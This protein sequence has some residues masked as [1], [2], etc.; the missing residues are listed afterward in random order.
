MLTVLNNAI[1]F[2]INTLT[3]LYVFILIARFILVY[4]RNDSRSPTTRLIAK[5]TDPLVRP[6][7]RFVPTLKGFEFATLLCLYLIEMVK[8]ILLGIFVFGF[9]NL[10]ALPILALAEV[11][12]L[13]I[14][15]FFYAII[16]QVI[17]SWVPYSYNDLYNILALITSPIM[18]PL[19]RLIPPIGGFDIT[20][21]PALI[22]LQLILILFID[23][24]YIVG[25]KL[26]FG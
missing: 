23:P 14:D 8:F 1:V 17:L 22:G 21:I 18:R 7:K 16:A 10:L 20:P 19:R 6:L 26:A 2:L 24:L 15:V 5:V 4:A 3:D 9:P 12:K 25:I 13:G 11:L